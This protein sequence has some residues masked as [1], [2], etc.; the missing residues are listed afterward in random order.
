MPNNP[1]Y[2]I[3]LEKAGNILSECE[4]YLDEELLTDATPEKLARINNLRKEIQKVIKQ[5]D[6][7][8]L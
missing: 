4:N 6:S 3:L 8:D 1:M 7:L 5:I 2:E